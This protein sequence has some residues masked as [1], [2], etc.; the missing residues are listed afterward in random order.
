M[1]FRITNQHASNF[2]R[3][4]HPLVKIKRHRVSLLDAGNKR[5][6]R[7]RQL[8]KRAECS[9]D[10]KPEVLITADPR[11]PGEVINR[12]GI[13]GPRVSDDAERS[14][15]RLSVFSNGSS[16]ISQVNSKVLVDGDAAKAAVPEPHQ[17]SG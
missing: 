12:S 14:E 3:Q 5:R 6:E 13:N 4:I 15:P 11:E 16:K 9:V 17:F 10:V 2:K 7:G 1:R 8:R